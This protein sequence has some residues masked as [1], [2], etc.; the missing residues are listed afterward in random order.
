MKRVSLRKPLP[1]L[2]SRSRVKISFPTFLDDFVSDTSKLRKQWTG[3]VVLWRTVAAEPGESVR[4]QCVDGR[5]VSIAEGHG[6]TQG[7]Y[8]V[9]DSSGRCEAVD[10]AEEAE[11]L[12][13]IWRRT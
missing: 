7:S 6:A 10:D 2:I 8:L 13:K 4:W 3:D 1:H 11:R 12:A 9:S 5:W